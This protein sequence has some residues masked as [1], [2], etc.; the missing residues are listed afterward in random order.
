MGTADIVF[1]SLSA[2]YLND[3]CGNTRRTTHQA[4]T[5]DKLTQKE[6]NV[7]D[8]GLGNRIELVSKRSKVRVRVANLHSQSPSQ[9]DGDE[10]AWWYHPNG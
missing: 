2:Q 7:S 5:C 1:F 8:L 6:A 4:M 10:D 3:T 9:R